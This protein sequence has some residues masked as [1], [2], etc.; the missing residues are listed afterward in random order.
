MGLLVMKEG[1][2]CTLYSQEIMELLPKALE[3]GQWNV[4]VQAARAMRTVC[5]KLGGTINPQV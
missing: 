2:D 4:K 3:S 5:T 1:S